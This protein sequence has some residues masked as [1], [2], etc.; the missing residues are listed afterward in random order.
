MY[1]ILGR[2]YYLQYWGTLVF[3]ICIYI[4]PAWQLNSSSS[5][6]SQSSVCGTFPSKGGGYLCKA[7]GQTRLLDNCTTSSSH[8]LYEDLSEDL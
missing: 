2:S 3:T 4:Y 5:T 1:K 6:A 7:A 8:N